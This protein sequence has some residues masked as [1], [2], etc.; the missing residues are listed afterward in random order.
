MTDLFVVGPGE[1]TANS[2][3]T[4]IPPPLL[5]AVTH[6][7]DLSPFIA[8]VGIMNETALNPTIPNAHR[9]FLSS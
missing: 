6:D 9:R 1:T 4:F 5:M 2:G 8:A 3:S 7:N